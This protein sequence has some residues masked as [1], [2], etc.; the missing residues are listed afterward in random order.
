MPKKN[1]L[2]VGSFVTQKSG[3]TGGQQYA[4]QS[5]LKSSELNDEINWLLL[6]T[7]ATT[8][9][10]RNFVERLVPAL[11]R[12]ALFFC[13]LCT[14]KIDSVFIF[15]GNGFSFIEKGLMC[16]IAKKFA[17]KIILSPR[18]EMVGIE[19]K[20][21]RRR[22][23]FTKTV[24]NACD[25]V[26]CQGNTVKNGLI[27]VV[28]EDKKYIILP[29][30]IDVE[31]YIQNRPQITIK[32]AQPLKILFLGWVD[33]YWKGIL[34]LIKAFALLKNT[35]AELHI[36]GDGTDMHNARNLVEQLGLSHKIV[37]HGWVQKVQKIELL[38]D[39][40]IFVL[41]SYS[42][43]YP[44]A[45]V[46]AMAAG[47]PCIAS[48]VGCIPDIIR[49]NENGCLIAAGNVA[50]IAKY[51]DILLKDA[52]LRLSMGTQ[53]RTDVLKNNTLEQLLPKIKKILV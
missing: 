13:F 28:F 17:K 43:G 46:E 19:A 33:Q 1:I 32:N 25:T 50:D 16:I 9:Q 53:A 41:P 22:F 5:L 49:H 23:L 7:T 45:L 8:N 51:L 12:L 21:S 36:A 39:S 47:L 20:Q 38:R 14:K 26:V 18:T 37:F 2:F 42:E 29:N 4:C 6:D 35:D 11:R 24:L 44:N 3:A 10:A 34:D 40:A 30:W 31:P 52:P 48:K 27:N 15:T